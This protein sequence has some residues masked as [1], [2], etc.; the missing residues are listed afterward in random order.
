[1]K[2]I[3]PYIDLP[4][5]FRRIEK[6]VMDEIRRVMIE[7]AFILRD[8][9]K[10][11]E[12]EMATFLG[13]KHVVGLNS[14]TDALYLAMKAAG[15]GPGDEVITV[16]NTF[17]ATIAAI[18]LSGARPVLVDIR[19]DFNMNVTCVETSINERTKAILPVHLNGRVCEMDTLDRV[20]KKYN[21]VIIEDACQSLGGMYKNKKAGSFGLI[22]CFSLHPMK[23][24]NCAGD[25][26]FVSTNDDHVAEKLRLL[27]DHGQ[28]TKE[29][30]VMFGYNSRLDNLQ[31]AI[32]NVKMKCLEQW[33]KRRRDIASLYDRILP[34]EKLILPVPPSN[35]DHY[36]V[37][38][39]YVVRTSKQKE[40][41][42][43]LLE[44]KVEVFVH[45]PKPLYL[46]KALRIET[47]RLSMNENI[48]SENLSLPI[49]PEMTD[50]QVHYV[51]KKISEFFVVCK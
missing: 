35:D 27:R 36:D 13:V 20:A 6:D 46:H 30:I 25:G 23:S 37:Y 7:G 11:F 19:D 47:D 39:S 14:G 31:A 3:V 28:K 22:G 32:V 16:A 42:S 21:L 5:Q 9:V 41:L 48:C 43:F 10:K 40:L 12:G 18:V 2:W 51:A 44:N 4:L 33:I 38:N 17:V 26:G 50:D 34:R 15:V 45:V 24:L 1:M 8:D 29:D 49:F